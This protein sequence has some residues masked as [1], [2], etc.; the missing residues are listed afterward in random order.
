MYITQYRRIAQGNSVDIKKGRSHRAE[1]LEQRLADIN[2][3][4]N[5][6]R[7]QQKT[8]VDLLSNK[9]LLKDTRVVT[10]EMWISFLQ[11]AGLDELGM[12]PWHK[13]FEETAPQAH[14]D[15]LE[16]LNLSKE[17]IIQIRKRSG[18]K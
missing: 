8:I 13:E 7:I 14:Q 6:L 5:H 4:I 2:D 11:A 10:K 1:L 18:S 9:K 12:M 15:F 16:S 17:E 3:E